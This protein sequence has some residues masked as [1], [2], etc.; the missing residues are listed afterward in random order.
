MKTNYLALPH[1]IDLSMGATNALFECGRT[2]PVVFT[3]AITLARIRT[4]KRFRVA[5]MR[6]DIE[7]AYG[8]LKSEM[9]A[10]VK[11]A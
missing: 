2:A 3:R 8:E 4:K 7:Q 6:K 5:L 11:D 10:L 1:D 9:D